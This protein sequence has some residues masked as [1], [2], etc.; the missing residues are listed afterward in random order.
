MRALRVVHHRDRGPGEPREVVD[1]PL[2]VHAHLDHG[3][4]MAL[5]QLEQRERHADVVVEIALGREDLL[6]RAGVHRQDR[7]QHF[8]DGRLAVAAREADD[9]QREGRAPAGGEAAECHAGVGDYDLAQRARRRARDQGCG[10]PKLHRTLDERMAIEALAL[11]RHEEVAR[12]DVAAVG[13][14]ARDLHVRATHLARHEPGGL[15]QVHHRV[16][17]HGESGAHACPAVH[18]ESAA[19]ATSRSLKGWR[20]PAISW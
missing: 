5:A 10:R 18:C 17:G 8:L 20:T 4:V 16:G 1:L 2:V 15:A 9:R 19:A 13:G 11:Q 3:E 12:R 14:H 7:R 6:A